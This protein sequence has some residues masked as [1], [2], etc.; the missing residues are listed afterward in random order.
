MTASTAAAPDDSNP[1]A[2]WQAPGAN[3]SSDIPAWQPGPISPTQ[4]MLHPPQ[5]C[6]TP[7][8]H[9]VSMEQ[10]TDM[11]SK[12]AVEAAA[13]AAQ[14]ATTA[15]SSAAAN[16]AAPRP[17]TESN[18]QAGVH[19]YSSDDFNRLDP[20][21][22]KICKQWRNSSMEKLKAFETHRVLAAKYDEPGFL[23]ADLVKERGK[24][25]FSRNAMLNKQK[26]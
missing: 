17:V 8:A 16:A 9:P 15:A 5:A 2:E 4:P 20:A 14:A 19:P 26:R 21:V 11:I 23:H 7:H 22:Q 13:A 1:W 6:P 25:W 18:R 12:V 3:G 10:I 24:K